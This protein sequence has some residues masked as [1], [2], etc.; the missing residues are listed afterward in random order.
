MRQ[1]IHDTYM[2]YIDTCDCNPYLIHDCNPYLIHSQ[3][4]TVLLFKFRHPSI[5]ILSLGFVSQSM[6]LAA[7]G[8]P[9]SLTSI[10]TYSSHVFLCLSRF[11]VPGSAY[12]WRD[13]IQDVRG[14]PY[15]SIPSKLMAVKDCLRDIQDCQVNGVRKLRVFR[16]GLWCQR[17]SGSWHGHCGGASAGQSPHV[18]LT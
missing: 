7:P 5:S 4:S 1:G 2:S 11:L 10:I 13:L 12:L 14:T 9:H 16:L 3:I 17:S 6:G 15:M 8:R 18:S